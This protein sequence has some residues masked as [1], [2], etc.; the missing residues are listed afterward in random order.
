MKCSLVEATVEYVVS[1][2]S[3]FVP[4]APRPA[5]LRVL[6]SGGTRSVG[7]KITLHL[8]AEGA[9]TP[10]VVVKLPRDR[11]AWRAV[12]L[13][14]ESLERC[15][16]VL[17]AE[18]KKSVPLPARLA[19]IQGR[20][21]AVTVFKP[22]RSLRWLC[23]PVSRR[24]RAQLVAGVTAA[25]E[26]L[27]KVHRWTHVDSLNLNEA[28]SSLETPLLRERLT[29]HEWLLVEAAAAALKTEGGVPRSMTHGDFVPENLLWDARTIAV[30]DW[31]WSQERG[32]AAADV[33]LLLTRMALLL[34]EVRRATMETRLTAYREALF[35][36]GWFART[37]RELLRR[38][39]EL[40]G[41]NPHL[42]PVIYPS[43][44]ASMATRDKRTVAFTSATDLMFTAVLTAYLAEARQGK[45]YVWPA[46]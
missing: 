10:S 22:G 42:L 12:E 44:L 41:L 32:V 45:P 17:S 27:G 3:D 43:V 11:A 20:P 14:A 38:Y 13:E 28:A 30:V 34:D 36:E 33:L 16:R 4:N 39:C 15:G 24:R 26:W 35:T 18:L 7:G 37:W 19:T 29:S 1:V 23:P 25:V 21:A 40:T 5:R 9:R 2:W 31:E 6:K 8:F 46:S